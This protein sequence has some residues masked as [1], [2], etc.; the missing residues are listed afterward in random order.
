MLYFQI[1]IRQDQVVVYDLKADIYGTRSQRVV[2]DAKIVIKLLY[3]RLYSRS[4]HR[5]IS[6]HSTTIYVCV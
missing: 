4:W 2:I 5:E 1:K 6:L 3:Y